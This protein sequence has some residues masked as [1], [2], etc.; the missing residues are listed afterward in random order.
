MKKKSYYIN[1]TKINVFEK[2]TDLFQTLY[3]EEFDKLI[4]GFCILPG[5]RTPNMLY[6][7]LAERNKLKFIISD[8][9]LLDNSNNLS[10]FKNITDILNINNGYPL[11]YFDEINLRGIEYLNSKLT[12]IKNNNSIDLSILG[13]GSDSHTA[14][15]F[16][17][18][19]LNF[20]SDNPGFVIKNG[21]DNFKRFTLSYEFLLSSN[22]IIFLVLGKDKSMAL[23]NILF[24]Q[25]DSLLYPA[26]EF[27]YNHS[28]VE[29]YC[30]KNATD[31]IKNKL[32]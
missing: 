23:K 6:D 28:N 30:D 14:S 25:K 1:S 10:N 29:I 11:S 18:Q 7:L 24:A 17:N 20:E 19:K 12:Q 21:N 26:Q 15:L 4:N 16:P 3:K 31:L 2:P 32:I 9:R 8:D 27:I 13:L 22:K 5:G